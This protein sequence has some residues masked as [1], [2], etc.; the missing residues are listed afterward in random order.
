MLFNK[1]SWLLGLFLLTNISL[2]TFAQSV[3][4]NNIGSA[5]DTSAMLDISSTT[6]GFLIPR[7]T[8]AQQNAILSPANGLIIFNTTSGQFSYNAGT[9]ATPVWNN[10]PTGTSMWN[11]SGNTGLTDA[12]NYIG[13]T[14][15]VPFNIHVNNQKA[16]RIDNANGIVSLGYQSLNS[17]SGT[18]NTAIGQASLFT[19]TSGTGITAVGYQSAYLNN[20]NNNI[21]ALGYQAG[22]NNV[23]NNN[24]FVGYQAGYTNTS[25]SGITAMGFKSLYA[26]STGG[27]N[28]AIG[29][30]ALQ[31]NNIGQ[32][33][34][35]VGQM[36]VGAN[37]SGNGNTG[38]GQSA[39]SSNSIGSYN[40]ALGASALAANTT[41]GSNV[42]VGQTALFKSTAGNY[43]TG[44]GFQAGY[45]DSLGSNN[46]YVGFQADQGVGIDT[47]LTNAT[48]IGFE[49][50]VNTNNSLILGGTG[51]HA[52]SVGIGTS[53]PT[54]T[55]DVIGKTKTANFQMTNG[56]TNGYVLT[57]DSSGNASW[58]ASASGGGIG[59]WGLVG[60]KGTNA[61]INFIGNI[62]SVSLQFKTDN[63]ARLTIDTLGRIGIGTISP[64]QKFHVVGTDTTTSVIA[65]TT[66]ILGLYE[67]TN[68]GGTS[69][70]LKTINSGHTLTTRIG[71]NP[72]YTSTGGN[73]VMA[74]YAN[75]DG[76]YRI[77]QTYDY[78]NN[79]LLMAPNIPGYAVNKVGINLAQA[80]LGSE[81]TVN[82]GLA[83][84][85]GASS[86]ST[87][88]AP[89]GGAIIEGKV[90]IGTS[91]P[92]ANLQV[93]GTFALNTAT[94][95]TA[96]SVVLLSSGTFST[97]TASSANSG[98]IY[99][100]RN[101]SATTAV[102]VTGIV[103][104]GSTTATNFNLTAATGVVMIISDG[105]KWWRIN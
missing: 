82:G 20:S 84:S 33:N 59:G 27:Y 98:M 11:T 12:T 26:N 71:I 74:W 15:N 91:S 92:N 51:A 90:G 100:I 43:K 58:L 63:V 19:N 21:T 88:T 13:T 103:N 66:N 96:N 42:A 46:T 22:Y 54:A 87:T 34:T 83:V 94:S 72:T 81:L 67:N 95:G 28:T 69:L 41:G 75:Y 48:A 99:I 6:K 36:A 89:A 47:A 76:N 17:N 80:T 29:A 73:G 24:S 39:L 85:N 53:S 30:N 78:V 3:A 101:T 52:V 60:N 2:K 9:S 14:D 32:T 31:A 18:N 38:I 93:N 77:L 8:T 102:T 45:N 79:N 68:Y 7:M 4:I 49:A 10:L 5:P 97:P 61:A 65:A 104:Y 40:T 86:F 44:V 56:A 35:A 1:H 105:N 23:T 55:L 70:D 16:G 62:D 37:T 50:K 57:S 25:G 64:A